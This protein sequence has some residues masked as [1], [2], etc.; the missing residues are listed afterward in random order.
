MPE[1]FH[2]HG[3]NRFSGTARL[4]HRRSSPTMIYDKSGQKTSETVPRNESTWLIHY[5]RPPSDNANLERNARQC[6]KCG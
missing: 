3:D 6:E 5:R 4:R 2:E 1:F